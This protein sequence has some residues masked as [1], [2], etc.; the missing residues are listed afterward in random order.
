MEEI[1]N[2][3]TQNSFKQPEIASEPS[4]RAQRALT[5]FNLILALLF[6]VAAL[7]VYEHWLYQREYRE[8]VNLWNQ[9]QRD[10]EVF[11]KFV[12]EIGVPARSKNDKKILISKAKESE[13]RVRLRLGKLEEV[14]IL[15]RHP[16]LKSIHDDM[17]KYDQAS[18]VL[19]QLIK[20]Y[21][22]EARPDG[23]DDKRLAEMKKLNLLII[24]AERNLAEKL[25]QV[26][27]KNYNP[28][29]GFYN[30]LQV[31]AGKKL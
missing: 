28:V 30:Y 3:I 16:A 5:I 23:K 29:D 22:F 12:N 18:L 9:S 24:P 4:K 31:A 1:P 20:S 17:L 6:M 7:V 26:S 10:Q 19:A 2:N 15:P 11:D 8:L 27:T 13:Y 25:W 14:A 21:I